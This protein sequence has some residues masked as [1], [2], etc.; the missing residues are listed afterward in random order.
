LGARWNGAQE[1]SRELDGFSIGLQERG[2]IAA[3]IKM[4]LEGATLRGLHSTGNV[5]GD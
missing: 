1:C 3:I 5:V 2:A 4:R